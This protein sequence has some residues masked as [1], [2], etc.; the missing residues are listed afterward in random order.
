MISQFIL[1]YFYLY[2]TAR[3]CPKFITLQHFIK[4]V[5]KTHIHRGVVDKY[6]DIQTDIKAKC[7]HA[8]LLNHNLIGQI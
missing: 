7:A 3:L 2:K 6:V 4:K 5:Q 8:D 1:I